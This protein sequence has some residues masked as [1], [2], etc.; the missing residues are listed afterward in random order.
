[1]LS[2]IATFLKHLREIS[3]RV[4]VEIWAPV[5]IGAMAAGGA[6]GWYAR[7]LLK[8]QRTLPP[9]P[10][11]PPPT[12]CDRLRLLLENDDQELWCLHK[13]IIPHDALIKLHSGKMKVLTL[14]NLKGGV[15]KTTS[16]EGAP[17]QPVASGRR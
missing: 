13:G 16:N 3:E 14:V 9:L 7:R 2:D 10:P 6:A 15:G 17:R 12:D 4:P 1:M 8:P 5:L 11:P